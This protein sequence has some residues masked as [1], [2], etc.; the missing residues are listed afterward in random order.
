MKVRAIGI[1]CL[2]SGV[3][4][5]PLEQAQHSQQV[6]PQQAAPAEAPEPFFDLEMM[7]GQGMMHRIMTGNVDT[8]AFQQMVNQVQHQVEAINQLVK[9]HGSDTNGLMEALVSPMSQLNQTLA[10][11]VHRLAFNPAGNT[12]NTVSRLP[13]VKPL[14]LLSDLLRTVSNLLENILTRGPIG[15]LLNGL[16]GG[17]LTGVA[18]TVGGVVGGGP[19]AQVPDLLAGIL[20]SIGTVV[21]GAGAGV[22]IKLP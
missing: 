7:M 1:L 14:T 9:E 10:V 22:G 6:E 5:L 18:D 4:A 16:L 12:V 19:A 17:I 21:P 3:L 11:G 2:I 20:G 8:E 13:A 15:G